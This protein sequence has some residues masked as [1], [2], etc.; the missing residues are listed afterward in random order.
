MKKEKYI[1]EF[2]LNNAS[3]SVLWRMISTSSGLSEW[4]A[5]EVLVDDDVY[6]FVWDGFKEVAYL[7]KSKDKRYVQFQWEDNVGSDIYFR[8]EIVRQKLSQKVALVITDFSFPADKKD[9]VLLWEKHVED[10]C[11]IAGM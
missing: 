8:L 1:L 5:D 4:F 3:G 11:R 10:L 9:D 7:Q 2:P 6:V